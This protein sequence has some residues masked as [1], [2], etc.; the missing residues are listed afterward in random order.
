MVSIVHILSSGCMNQKSSE[1]Y[2]RFASFLLFASS[3][4]SNS[5]RKIVRQSKNTF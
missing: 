5:T 4:G 2:N 3:V 1:I